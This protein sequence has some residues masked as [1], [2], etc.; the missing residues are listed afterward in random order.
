MTRCVIVT[1]ASAGLGRALARDFAAAGWIVAAVARSEAALADLAGEAAGVTALP[2]DVTDPAA[3]AEMTARAL[4]LTGRIDALV[5]CA[6]IDRPGPIEELDP[7]E[8]QRI[9]AVNL[10]G[11]FLCARAVVPA[12]KA[13]GAGRIVNV[14][15]VAGKRGA[16]GAVAYC[17]TKAGL[18]GLSEA[19]ALELRPHGIAVTL[20]SPGGMD[21]GWTGAARPDFTAPAHAA[22]LIRTLVE[23]PDDLW[24]NEVVLTPPTE[25]H[26]P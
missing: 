16:P 23:Q 5:N 21:T 3:V 1:G 14:G 25:V 7:A 17:A 2:C 6:G 12:M 18:G 15:S 4:S 19:L 10:S 22:R 13:A 24:V 9:L 11:A 26:Y 20:V 8:W